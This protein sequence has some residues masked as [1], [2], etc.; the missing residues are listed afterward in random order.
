VTL[1]IDR[2]PLHSWLDNTRTPPARQW[3]VRLPVLPSPSV[4]NPLPGTRPQ[5]WAVDTGFTG[6]AF[7]WRHHLEDA[8][9]DP[10]T[11]RGTPVWLKGSA[12]SGGI[13]AP[14]RKADLWLVSNI[15]HLPPYCLRLRSGI[16]FRDQRVTNPD[17]EF[18]RA[19]LGMRPLI[20]AGLKV[21]LDFAGRTVSVWIP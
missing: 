19:L 10:D 15:A 1:L 12:V 18:H 17:P 8:G 4:A 3:S 7:A 9:L 20:R 13:Q 16:T 5:S 14:V 11:R 6:D 2:L 21:E